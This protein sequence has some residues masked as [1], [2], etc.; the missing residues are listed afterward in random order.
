MPKRKNIIA[1]LL[2]GLAKIIWYLLKGIYEAFN[3]IFHGIASLFSKARQIS[4]EKKLENQAHQDRKQI[5]GKEFDEIESKQGAIDDFNHTLYEKKSTIGLILGARGT[6]KSAL[7]LRILE[8]VAARTSK[9]AYAMGFKSL[10]SWISMVSR[11]EDVSPDSFLIIDESGITFSSRNFMKELNKF[12][13]N[14][15]LVS[16]H[17]DLSVLFITQ[18]SSN[19]EINIIRQIDYLLLKPSSLL[20]NEFERKKI[21]NIYKENAEDFSKYKNVKG[22]TYVYSASYAGFISNGLPSFWTENISKS[23]R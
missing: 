19:I 3:F 14:L 2:I 7:G 17:K 15:L 22:L 11:L 5:S 10:P 9:K 23:F 1:S 13:S 12:L 18:N 21:S 16:R 4:K 8:N 20:Q 6:G